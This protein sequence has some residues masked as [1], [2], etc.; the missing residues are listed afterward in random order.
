MRPQIAGFTLGL[1]FLICTSAAR[2]KDPCETFVNSQSNAAAGV[3]SILTGPKDGYYDQVGQALKY[4][5]S[6]ANL[7]LV[8]I[9]SSGSVE[10]ICAL[11]QRKADFALVQSDAAHLAWYGEQPF[12]PDYQSL[13]LIT[14]IFVEKVHIL[15]RPQLYI[16]SPA[17]LSKSHSVWLGPE[18]SGS[19]LSAQL[20][21][22][23]SGKSQAQ[24][25]EMKATVTPD[26]FE[27]AL[28]ELKSWK[29]DAI[30]ETEVAPS[31]DISNALV[32]NGSELRLLGLDWPSAQLLA[33][34]GMYIDTSLQ[35]AEYSALDGGLYTVGV[36]ALL[37]TRRDV[38]T[39]AVTTLAKLLHDQ[40]D[41]IITHLQLV[42][43]KES[44]LNVD[45][46]QDKSLSWKQSR[47]LKEPQSLS[48]LGVRVPWGIVQAADPRASSFLWP[49]RI[50]REA[51]IQILILF[52]A[53]LV[54]G[55][56]LFHPHARH[57]A[58][59]NMRLLLFL[60]AYAIFLTIG[61]EWL[62]AIEGGLN[63]HFTTLA[64]SCLSLIEN[65]IAKLQVPIPG[66]AT[67]TSQHGVNIM[68]WFSWIGFVL[69][70]V[71]ALPMLKRVVP[72]M[73]RSKIVQ[74]LTGD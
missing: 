48:L 2:A 35:R 43:A 74:F 20:V 60:V 49:Y 44:G 57:F 70:T 59:Q 38:N 37:L 12:D 55:A 21:L 28:A 9:T 66:L 47:S 53:L 46:I 30:F 54:V 26:T 65:V 7:N 8:P 58:G 67:P 41:D 10:N 69:L 11:R 14:P 64:A 16:S 34:N 40:G 31:A 61:G 29:L 15:V 42:M 36:E 4:S 72:G 13:T 3:Y 62:Q 73:W 19:Q 17:G 27:E 1:A 45:P 22:Q 25:E 63:P 18:N 33:A 56:A 39:Q 6:H 68:A 50:P 52:L 32:E 71:Y 23:A 24:I 5:A 51:T